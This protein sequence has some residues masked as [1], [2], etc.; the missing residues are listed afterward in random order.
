MA[1]QAKA[2]ETR[3]IIDAPKKE[4]TKK[5][6]RE[7]TTKTEKAEKKVEKKPE[8]K[9][10]FACV[11]IKDAPISSKD[12]FDVCKF[13]K[14]KT[15]NKAIKDLEKV[16]AGKKAIP[17]KGEIPHRKGKIMSGRFPKVTSEHFIRIIKSLGANSNM[18]GLE[19]P[20]IVEAIANR[21]SRPF[22][23]FGAIRRKRTHL[24]LVAK[25][26][27]IKEEKK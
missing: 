10:E 19:N 12:A 4:E 22:G 11:N 18:N 16:V 26:K 25:E 2:A 13:I 5:E 23:R 17:M 1:K 15:I 27:K 9:K 3:K 21:A 7:E 8:V 20:V 6:T 24:R 14:F